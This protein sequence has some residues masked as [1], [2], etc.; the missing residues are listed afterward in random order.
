MVLFARLIHKDALL[1]SKATSGAAGFDL[2]AVEDGEILP[3][4]TISFSTGVCL[5]IPKGCCG[6]IF[7]R[8]SLAKEQ[9]ITLGGIIDCDY[10]GELIVIL[11]NLSSKPYMVKKHE[12]IAQLVCFPYLDCDVRRTYELS[13][14][15]RGSQAFGSTGK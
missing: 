11:H 7:D 5:E 14:T 6:K 2:Y 9:I 10:R 12:R 4:K 3:Q 15:K 1:P 13:L 8:S